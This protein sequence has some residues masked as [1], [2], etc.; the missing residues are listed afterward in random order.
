MRYIYYD[1]VTSHFTRSL[2]PKGHPDRYTILFENTCGDEYV[3]SYIYNGKKFA[4]S[5]TEAHRTAG[6]VDD[7]RNLYFDHWKL[8]NP[9]LV[10]YTIPTAKFTLLQQDEKFEA[11]EA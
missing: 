4:F 10:S 5:Y 3:E 2:D 9:K 1:N 6:A 7:L 8:N 11:L